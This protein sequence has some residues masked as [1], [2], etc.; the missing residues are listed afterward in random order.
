MDHESIPLG[1]QMEMM[2]GSLLL[3]DMPKET[4]MAVALK[5]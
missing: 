4:L 5:Y 1:T 3:L 2:R